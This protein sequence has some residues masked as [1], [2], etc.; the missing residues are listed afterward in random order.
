MRAP[1]R[2]AP[3][4]NGASEAIRPDA[5]IEPGPEET[6]SDSGDAGNTPLAADGVSADTDGA[7]QGHPDDYQV[8]GAWTQI[9]SIVA[10]HK[11]T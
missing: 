1:E 10:R 5:V 11:T 7:S 3:R 8:K 4:K 6:T 9:K 2:Q